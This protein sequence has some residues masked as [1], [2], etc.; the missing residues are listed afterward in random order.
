MKL[1]AGEI[2]DKLSTYDFGYDVTVA[3][4]FDASSTKFPRIVVYEVVNTP[5]VI[6]TNGERASTLAYQ[7]NLYTKDQVV[8]GEVTGR[9][10]MADDL[11]L[12][13]NDFIVGEYGMNRDEAGVDVQFSENVNLRIMRYS[14]AIGPHDYTYNH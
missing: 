10:E 14:C 11:A 2:K 12:K 13:L 9:V 1:L 3:R 7:F 4:T 6:T 8:D 5:R